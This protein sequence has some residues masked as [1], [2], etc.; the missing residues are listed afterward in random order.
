M[1][2]EPGGRFIATN[3]P[4]R[5]VIRF[6]YRVQDFQLE[7]G[8]GWIASDRFDIAATAGGPVTTEVMRRLVQQLLEERFA[9]RVRRDQRDQPIYELSVASADGRLGPNLRPATADCTNAPVNIEF[10]P[11]GVCGRFGPDPNLPIRMGRLAFRGLPMDSF[12]QSITPAVRRMV[13]N[14]TG[15][16]G[17]YDAEL[18]ASAELPPPPPPP[19]VPDPRGL[20]TLPSIFSVLRDQLGLKLES[21]R[22]PVE[23][24]VIEQ[25][26]PPT[27]D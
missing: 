3:M 25:V 18:D 13:V 20:E 4:L 9:L 12:A 6:A 5:A 19:G 1:R 2:T 10:N 22:G 14:R 16:T 7:N 8:P 24:I 23:V 15:L 21:S 17:Y 27:P 11:N 26:Q